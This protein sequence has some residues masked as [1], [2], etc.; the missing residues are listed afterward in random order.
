MSDKI[1]VLFDTDIGSDIDD[2]VCLAY[3]LAQPRCEL[4]GITTVS[5][6]ADRRAML[7]SAIC[8]SVDRGD[9]PIH[10]GSP[11][12][13]LTPI[14]QPHA[15]QAAILNRWAH[16]LDFPAA[17]AVEFMRQTI[18]ERPG[19]IILLAV[20]PFTN[21]ALL[22]AGDPEIPGMLRGL[23]TMGGAFRVGGGRMYLQEWNAIND[24]YASAIMYRAAV[25]HTCIGLDVTTQCTMPADEVRTRFHGGALHVVADAAEVW[26][27][28][29]NGHITFH[30]P[31]AGT[32]IF[33]PEICQYED[34]LVEV[35]LA[36]DKLRGMTHWNPRADPKPHRVATSVDTTA[37]FSEYFSVFV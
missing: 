32:I 17:K 19:E 1:P 29:A 31:L 2:A 8:R 33:K 15:E 30:D 23:V 14:L 37:F 6:E 34:G 36:S 10:V 25:P 18:R 16:D 20:G 9:I 5:G 22:F 28:D 4:V 27:R 3:L 26:F 21:V 24:P 35:E 7:A 11:T 13:L 12:P